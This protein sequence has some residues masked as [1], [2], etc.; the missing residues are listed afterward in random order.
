MLRWNGSILRRSALYSDSMFTAVAQKN[1]AVAQAYF[2]EHLSHNDY[3]T[4]GE[5]EAGHWIGESCR[6]LQ[7]IEGERVE[8]DLFLNLCENLNPATKEHLTQRQRTSRR[9]FF[10]FTCSAPKSVS[11]LAVTLND[12]RIVEAHQAAATCALKELEQFAGTRIRKGGNQADRTTANIVAAEFL[13]TSSRAL[14]PQLHTHFTVFNCTFDSIEQQ[15]KA[16]QTSGMFGAIRYATEVYRNDLARRLHGIGYETIRAS[17]GFEIKN[18]PKE[19]CERFSKRAK[20]RDEVIWEMERKLGR[21]LSNNQVAHVIHR[22][23][24]RKLKGIST[25]EV[26]Q[27]QLRQLSREELAE[28]RAVR[29]A[30]NG[31]PKAQRTVS[32]DSALK[33]AVDHLFE[34]SS[35]V[36]REDILQ[37][38]LIEGRGQINL[39]SLKGKI[40]ADKKFVRIGNELSLRSILE[41][42]L[43]LIGMMNGGKN[44]V[45]P[46]H[47]AFTGSAKLGNDQRKAL[48]NILRS[49]DQFTGFR[50]LA[51]TGKSTLLSELS[52]ALIEAG[53]KG[54]FCAPTAA[55]TDVL[56]KQGF[57]AVTL[58][59]LLIDSQLQ[60]ALTPQS[61]IVLDEAGAVSLDDMHKL[62]ALAVERGARVVLCGDTGQH[63]AVGRGDALRILEKHSRYSFGEL[64]RIRRQQRAEYLCAVQLA[65]QHKPQQAFDRLDALGSVIEEP[66]QLHLHVAEAYLEMSGPGHSALI[67]APTWNE[68]EAVTEQIRAKL[69]SRGLLEEGEQCR[70]VLESLGWSEAE[71]RN[72]ARYVVGQVLVFHQR[73]GLFAKHESVTV[74]SITQRTLRVERE[75]GTVATLRL[76]SGKGVFDVCAQRTIA[77]APGEKL[78]L[79]ANDSRHRLINGQI[80]RVKTIKENGNIILADG[81]II[82]PN[83]RQFTHG[84]AVTSH[85]A[86]GKT[87]DEVFV[88]ASTRSLPAVNREQ[89][90][91]SI[92]RGRQ[93]CRIFTD[94][95]ELLRER[96][97]RTAQRTAAI[98]LATLEIALKR[99]GFSAKIGTE[100]AS[101][102]HSRRTQKQVTP[103]LRPERVT[104]QRLFA[105]QRV[106]FERWMNHLRF[107]TQQTVQGGTFRQ[108]LAAPSQQ[109]HNETQST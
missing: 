28:L 61:V 74:R 108:Q 100:K 10:D 35:V 34:R 2:D 69:K 73:S 9:I 98:E 72:A 50:G 22:T 46:L 18:V 83:Y 6:R 3:Y 78:L 92:S 82:P 17:N 109:N 60:Q 86:Q 42:E 43:S 91:V 89:F 64:T 5:V 7:L 49:C 81:R 58:Q 55:A 36:A 53:H 13:H 32:D 105:S 67:V 44:V 39:E 56:Q 14:D 102:S 23:R 30:A 97:P 87:V 65:A 45:V 8:R 101:S 79:Q 27:Y 62:F 52:N 94:D 41:T 80:V 19:L 95:K 51:G 1:R 66:E 15:W 99:A 33:Y 71:K 77:I 54:V 26:R 90:Y 104:H 76:N 20:Q 47:P 59:R 68:I 21:K 84:Y 11:I 25:D 75:N 93:W 106:M 31:T 63:P 70:S 12:R 24:S 107:V 29:S 16:L 88:V 48:R 40:A 85:A 38:A 103:S 96:L 4:Q 37:H 57:D